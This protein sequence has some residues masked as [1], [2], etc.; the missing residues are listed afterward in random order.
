MTAVIIAVITMNKNV[1]IHKDT[2]SNTFF[3]IKTMV[4]RFI[5][6][7]PLP[8]LS[9]YKQ[10]IYLSARTPPAFINTFNISLYFHTGD[11]CFHQ[12]QVLNVPPSPAARTK[13]P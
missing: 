9:Q 1:K 4:S 8:L 10:D 6:L 7:V 12:I 5:N 11:D 3:G 13:S 2:K